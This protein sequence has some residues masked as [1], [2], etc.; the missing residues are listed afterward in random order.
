[1]DLKYKRTPKRCTFC[2]SSKEEGGHASYSTCGEF[3]EYIALHGQKAAEKELERRRSNPVYDGKDY[4]MDDDNYVH[5]PN[6]KNYY[7]DDD[8]G[9]E[10][11]FIPNNIKGVKAE[12]IRRYKELNDKYID[13]QQRFNEMANTVDNV[14]KHLCVAFV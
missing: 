11:E 5:D 4:E 3:K 9:V 10:E 7:D 13:L 8:E 6:S 12:M 14:G 2:R 1:M